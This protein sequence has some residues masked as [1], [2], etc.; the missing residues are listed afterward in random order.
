MKKLVL[1]C[2]LQALVF[3]FAAAQANGLSAAAQKPRN[4]IKVDPAP[5][6]VPAFISE[7]MERTFAD[8]SGSGFKAAYERMITEY[9]SAGVECAY[10]TAD[11]EAESF[12]AAI[13]SIDAG[14]HGRFYPSGKVFYL[15]AGVG[16]VMFDFELSGSISALDNFKEDFDPYTGVGGTFD[17]GFGWRWLLGGHFIVDASITSGVY[18]GNAVSATTLFKLASAGMPALSGKA[19][20]FRLDAA[21]ALGWAF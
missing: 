1:V 6:L 21:I 5:L 4:E 18:L 10:I 16:L 17:I 20:P 15:E 2:V 9:V 13:H 7:F 3:Q 14:I 19:F 12:E 8:T 11:V